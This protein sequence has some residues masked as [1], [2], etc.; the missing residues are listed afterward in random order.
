MDVA[1]QGRPPAWNRAVKPRAVKPVSLKFPY[2]R[3]AS[4]RRH[5]W[6]DH[7]V[8][9]A[10][11]AGALSDNVEYVGRLHAVLERYLAIE[12]Q[13]LF[14]AYLEAGGPQTLDCRTKERARLAQTAPHNAIQ[15]G[16]QT[17]FPATARHA[18]RKGGS[19]RLPRMPRLGNCSSVTGVVC[20]P[21]DET[22]GIGR[23]QR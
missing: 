17:S 13:L 11:L 15:P 22:A 2:R 5:L 14:P 1:D 8:I 18:Q 19:D 16:F 3:H 7:A 21:S 9:E 12:A 4:T 20:L 6:N 23:K 10:A